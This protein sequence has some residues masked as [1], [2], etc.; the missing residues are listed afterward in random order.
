M[1]TAFSNL[2]RKEIQEEVYP[3]KYDPVK[4][5]DLL[6]SLDDDAI[7]NLT[8]QYANNIQIKTIETIF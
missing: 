7:R 5:I 6:D 1:S 8:P 3:C 2:D 4:L